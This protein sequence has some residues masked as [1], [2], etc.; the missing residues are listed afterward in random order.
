[1]AFTD[2]GPHSKIRKLACGNHRSGRLAGGGA[3]RWLQRHGQNRITHGQRCEIVGHGDGD[4]AIGTQNTKRARLAVERDQP[5]FRHP[6]S[7]GGK[8]RWRHCDSAAFGIHHRHKM[9]MAAAVNCRNQRLAAVRC[10]EIDNE[11]E[12]GNGERAYQ[13]EP[14][15]ECQTRPKPGSR[16]PP[17]GKRCGDAV[18][19]FRRRRN[20]VDFC[21]QRGEARF[22]C[23]NENSRK[24]ARVPSAAPRSSARR[25]TA[26]RAHIRQR[27]VHP[28]SARYRGGCRSLIQTGLQLNQGATDRAFHCAERHA[29]PRG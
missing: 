20:L 10:A 1:M 6:A 12:A 16:L 7:V 5:Q 3:T 28:R 24:R 8:S 21:D 29:R 17:S 9:V 22:P 26:R 15:P 27:S 14:T 25:L 18:P 4:R 19:D 13:A 11:C 23:R 2:A